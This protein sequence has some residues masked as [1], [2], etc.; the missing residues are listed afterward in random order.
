MITRPRLSTPR[1]EAAHIRMRAER[2]APVVAGEPM[3]TVHASCGP[4]RIP[5]R[6]AEAMIELDNAREEASSQR[7]AQELADAE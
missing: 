5:L 3:A 6:Y 4:F 1:I 7:R 2:H